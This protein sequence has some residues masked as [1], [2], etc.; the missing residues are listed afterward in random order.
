MRQSKL[1]TKVLKDK[2]RDEESLNAELLLRGGFAYKNS[3]G[4]FTYLP[5]GWRVIQKISNIIREEMNAIGGEELLMPALVE[6]KYLDAS[7]RW[8]VPVGFEAKTKNETEASFVL[9]WTHEEVLT[10]I[11]SK[12]INSYRDLPF[13]AYQIQTKFRNEPRAKSGLLRGREFMMKDLYSFHADE[14]DFQEYYNVVAGAY[15]KV[16]ERCGLKAYYTLAAGGDFTANYTHEF[17]VLSLVGEDTIL[18]CLV[19]G[20]AENGEIS[21]LKDSDKCPKC[22]E[23]IKEEKAIEV[24]NIFP[25]GTKYSKSFNLQFLDAK[26]ERHDVVMGSYG[27]GVSRL[28]GTIVEVSHDENGIIWPESLAPFRVHLIALFG[29]EDEAILALAEKSYAELQ[30]NGVEVLYDDRQ[31]VSAGEKFAEADLIGIPR[32]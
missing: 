25:L 30:K 29:K 32:R 11:A 13:A 27:I 17:Q 7:G 24:G 2:P 8:D 9:G 5:L 28:M 16:F 23:N 18:A 22:G 14:K 10:D 6:K 19:C 21:K 12:Y 20:Y 15:H 4:V 31:D 3:A 26:G 1:F